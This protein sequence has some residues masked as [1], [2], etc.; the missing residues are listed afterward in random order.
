MLLYR[1][2]SKWNSS[3][4]LYRI[5][6]EIYE[7]LINHIKNE[8]SHYQDY[9]INCPNIEPKKSSSKSSTSSNS[10]KSFKKVSAL[11]SS[12]KNNSKILGAKKII[13]SLLFLLIFKWKLLIF[14]IR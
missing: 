11:S 6:K 4:I 3:E 10:T 1:I 12:K 13:Y 9:T 2:Q 8:Q 5:G 14:I 7:D